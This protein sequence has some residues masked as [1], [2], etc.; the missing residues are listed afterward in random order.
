MI[1][2]VQL[3]TEYFNAENFEGVGQGISLIAGGCSKR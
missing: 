1:L 2:I 3:V